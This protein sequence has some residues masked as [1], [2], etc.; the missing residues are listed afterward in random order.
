VFSCR[1]SLACL[2]GLCAFAAG[3]KSTSTVSTLFSRKPEA[4]VVKSVATPTPSGQVQII[5]DQ[6]MEIQWQVQTAQDQ[7]GQVKSG[8]GLIGPDGTVVVGPYGT[9]KVAGLTLDKAT[10]AFEQQLAPYM[11]APSVQLS[12]ALSTPSADNPDL[13]WRSAQT[14]G[15]STVAGGT[16]VIQDVV[17]LESPIQND[18]QSAAWRR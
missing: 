9:C 17:P 13:T 14:H 12:T 6:G 15:Q 18:V 8:K 5:L 11:K 2:A 3:C 7:P 1:A 4:V 16:P 10:L